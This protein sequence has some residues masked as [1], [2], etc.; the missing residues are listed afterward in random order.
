MQSSS[1]EMLYQAPTAGLCGSVLCSA[2][3]P[4]LGKLVTCSTSQA[5]LYDLLFPLFS[6]FLAKLSSSLVRVV[7]CCFS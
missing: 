2:P 1:P 5:G 7:L 6:L 3:M 4:L